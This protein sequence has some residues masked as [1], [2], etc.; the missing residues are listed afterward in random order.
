MHPLQRIVL[1]LVHDESGE[2]LIEYAMA[3]GLVGAGAVVALRSASS[4]VGR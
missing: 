3:A 1:N 2:D 4:N